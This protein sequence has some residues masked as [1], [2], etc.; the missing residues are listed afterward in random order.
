MTGVAGGRALA[1]GRAARKTVCPTIIA[2]TSRGS[3]V[4]AMRRRR[5]T[6]QTKKLPPKSGNAVVSCS[7]QLALS[8]TAALKAAMS[9][10]LREPV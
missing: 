7:V 9:A 4:A 6:P 3:G 8:S 2:M 10:A 1:I 5:P